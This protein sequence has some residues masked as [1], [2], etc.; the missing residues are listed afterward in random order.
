MGVGGARALLRT[1]QPDGFDCPGCAWP[2]REHGSTFEF[3]EN[4]AKAVAAEATRHRA[5]PELFARHSVSTLAEYSDH[6]L[7]QQGR[8][9]TP[10]RYDAASDHYVPASWGRG[11]LRSS[12][13]TPMPCPRLTK[14]CSYTSGPHVQQA[15]FLLP[16][17]RARVRHEQLPGLL[18]HVPRILGHGAKQRY[19]RRQ[20]HGVAAGFRTG[21]RHPRL[22]P[23]PGTNHP[24]MLASCA[25]R[26]S[27]AAGSPPSTLRERGLERFARIQDTLE[28][29]RGGSTRIASG[30][31]PA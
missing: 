12:R 7:E 27:A 19:R 13:S 4:G 5:G 3:C 26:R 11:L 16:A 23:E 25:M 18:E 21:R 22:R 24:R 2:D 14:R 28:M 15:A 30:L 6:W 10:M 20:G 29:A 17:V 31:L 8:L 9:T 1:N